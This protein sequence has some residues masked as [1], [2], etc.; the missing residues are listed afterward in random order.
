[1]NTIQSINP[2]T[3]TP[4]ASYDLHAAGMVDHIVKQSWNCFQE[5]Q[6]TKLAQ[7]ANYLNKLAR[8][9]RDRIAELSQLIT[10]EV[11]KP[12]LQSRAEIEKCAATCEFYAESAPDF[13]GLQHI[14]TEASRSYVR[15]D[16]IGPVLAV[17]P[18][19]FP[20][21][22]VFRFAAPALMAGN[23]ALLKHASNVTGCALAMEQLFCEAGF[24]AH[25][26]QTLVIASSQVAAVIADDRVRA[27]TLTGSEAAG[28]SVARQ[29]GA[30]LK[31]CVLELGGADPFIVLADAD[32]QQ[33]A[34]QATRAR[35]MNNGQSCI[36]AKRFLVADTVF[37]EFAEAMTEAMKAL[38]MG[39]PALEFN[40]IGP[41]A[42]GDLRTELH[43]QVENTLHGG[44]GLTTGGTIPEGPGFY[45]PPTVLTN[46]HPG[47]SAFD[48]ELFGPVAALV[49]FSSMTDAILLAN[50]SRF[51]LGASIWTEDHEQAELMAARIESG[52]VFINEITRSDARLPFGGVKDSGFGREL[53]EFGIRE[54]TNIKTVW[55]A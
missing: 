17:M 20:F 22:Q 4:I 43:Q 46:V 5:W 33:T 31:K 7:R 55:V 24:P 52:A 30:S 39:D 37:D 21:W 11:G 42:R 16:P 41:L 49:R 54:F 51:G 36:A 38:Q 18:W 12:I 27:V 6:S 9:L 14:Q 19:N 53:G 44:A 13:L 47:M 45:Y 1:M 3:E 28:R 32:I 26:F 25:A 15:F 48:E 29:A 10:A 8:L 40:D 2:A 23:V 35:T 34:R 50:Q